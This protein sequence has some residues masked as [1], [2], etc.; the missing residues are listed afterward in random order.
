VVEHLG[1]ASD[2]LFPG[3]AAHVA[4]L[5]E[6]ADALDPVAQIAVLHA[7]PSA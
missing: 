2:V 5:A 6:V 1:D 4:Q 3:R 7:A